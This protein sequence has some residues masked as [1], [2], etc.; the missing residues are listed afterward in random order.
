MFTN[1]PS[2]CHVINKIIIASFAQGQF[3]NVRMKNK[4]WL[5][6][7]KSIVCKIKNG[8]T[9]KFKLSTIGFSQNNNHKF[10]DLERKIIQK[11]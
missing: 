8:N 6:Q 2:Y 1:F 9:I 5:K 4:L 10:Y 7:V 3:I 11:N